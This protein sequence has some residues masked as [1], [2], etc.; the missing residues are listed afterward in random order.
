MSF[1]DEDLKRLKDVAIYDSKG[2]TPDVRTEGNKTLAL[3]AR[4]EA[5]EILLERL[6]NPEELYELSDVDKDHEL[7]L[8]WLKSKGG[9]IA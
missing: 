6:T 3:L 9:P 8:A 7:Y 4:L 2:H 1:T 5:A